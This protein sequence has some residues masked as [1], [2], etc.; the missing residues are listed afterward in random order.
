ME[1]LG[2]FFMAMP[3]LIAGLTALLFATLIIWFQ[4]SFFVGAMAVAITL[5]ANSMF[6]LSSLGLRL[7]V[8]L[9]IPDFVFGLIAAATAYRMA[10]VREARLGVP[11]FTLLAAIMTLNLGLGLMQYGAAAGTAARTSFYAMVTC[12]YTLSFPFAA[13][14]I[15]ELVKVLITAGVLL[16]G[17][18][19]YRGVVVAFDIRDLL[20]QSGSFQPA[21]HSVWRVI[22][23]NDTLLLAELA[24]LLWFHHRLTPAL[25]SWRWVA[26]V[27]LCAVIALQHRSVW[28]AML[29]GAGIIQAYST[30]ANAKHAV[31]Q[32]VLPLLMVVAVM[33]AG[34]KFSGSGDGI[35]GDIAKSTSDALQLRGT[36]GE[37][38]GGWEQA[39]RQWAGSGPRG[40]SLGRPFGASN[41]RYTS[42]E[43]GARKVVYQ[44][45]NY[46]VELIWNQGIIGLAAWLWMYAVAWRAIW[47]ARR[48]DDAGT[49]V[50]GSFLGMLLACQMT[51]Y[52]TYGVDTLQV[53]TLAVCLAWARTQTASK[54]SLP[55]VQTGAA[56]AEPA[57]PGAARVAS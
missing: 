43:L 37:R 11:A 30:R 6:Y 26:P 46:Y 40:L 21:G 23:S 1:F 20:P 10:T 48:S 15:K 41:E 56:M 44:P 55:G 4:S 29:V 33:A 52:L 38:L 57:G 31:L 22:V 34:V 54:P 45:H 3:Y 32:Q 47:R 51:Y 16:A 35:G 12:A 25:G 14:R 7:G 2:Y 27:L 18:A 17:L 53:L 39:L 9:Y 8:A 28:L 13:S 5:A 42:D 50:T 24:L 49:V 19:I 36:A